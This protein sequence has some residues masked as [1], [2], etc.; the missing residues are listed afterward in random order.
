M[1]TTLSEISL[2]FESTTFPEIYMLPL[3]PKAMSLYCVPP[4][5]LLHPPLLIIIA[6]SLTSVTV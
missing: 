1:S 5:V 3:L 4:L 2:V 6:Q